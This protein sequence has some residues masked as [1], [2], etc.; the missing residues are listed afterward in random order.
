M[1]TIGGDTPETGVI[2]ESAS[3]ESRWYD[4]PRFLADHA[5][6]NYSARIGQYLLGVPGTVCDNDV[7]PP[8]MVA[9]AAGP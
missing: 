8:L 6:I 9:A 4:P 1:Q 2:A 5:P 7:C 3:E